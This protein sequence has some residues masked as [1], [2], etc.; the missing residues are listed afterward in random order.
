VNA[1]VHVEFDVNGVPH[2]VRR[3]SQDGALQIKIGSD[4]M[5]PCTEEEVRT[6]PP[7]QTYSQKQLS[8]VSVRVEELSRFITVPIRNE[9]NRIERQT[10]DRSERIR[11][12]YAT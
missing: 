2:V 4:A 10:S 6:L 3:R 1:R 12:T 8:D 7:I 11:Q 9:L 5:R